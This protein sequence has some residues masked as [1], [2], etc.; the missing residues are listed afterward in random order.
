MNTV[1]LFSLSQSLEILIAIIFRVYPRICLVKSREILHVSLP[2]VSQKSV[3]PCQTN[4]TCSLNN[5][6]A[7]EYQAA[8]DLAAQDLQGSP[9]EQ[10][11]KPANLATLCPAVLLLNLHK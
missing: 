8:L 10:P 4:E 6:S 1:P 5:C 7:D 11:A 2:E 3:S 9:G